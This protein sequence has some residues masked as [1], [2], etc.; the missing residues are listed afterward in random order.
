M[1][2]QTD[3]TGDA[4]AGPAAAH[5]EPPA[6]RFGDP[7]LEMLPENDGRA[8]GLVFQLRTNSPPGAMSA[9]LTDDGRAAT[10]MA[11]YPDHKGGTIRRAVD[12]ASEFIAENP[13]GLTSVRLDRNRAD[14]GTPAGSTSSAGRTASTTRSARSCRRAR[15]HSRSDCGTTTGRR[16]SIPRRC[17]NV[18]K[19][20]LP[21]WIGE[22]RTDEDAIERF[23]R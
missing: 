3:A 6:L 13:M 20:G 5:G 22:F 21:P 16:L 18:A 15:T 12:V 17:A 14:T 8:R 7:K 19:H 10:M 2:S 23:A 1:L 9:L 11:F 4:V